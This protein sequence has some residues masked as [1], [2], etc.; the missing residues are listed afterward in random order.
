MSNKENAKTGPSK[1][2]FKKVSAPK[3]SN[4]IGGSSWLTQQEGS[5]NT[6]YGPGDC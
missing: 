3:K 6:F 1:K 5:Q 2:K 4:I